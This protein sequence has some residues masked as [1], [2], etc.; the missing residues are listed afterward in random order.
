MGA[1]IDDN[2]RFL[3]NVLEVFAWCRERHG[4]RSL[5]MA[6]VADTAT[7]MPTRDAATRAIA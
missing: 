5:T 7:R 4:M 6:E 3:R 1:H 2:F